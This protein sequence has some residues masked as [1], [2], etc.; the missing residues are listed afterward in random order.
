MKTNKSAKMI[1]ASLIGCGLCC[2]ALFLPLAAGF[3]GASVFGFSLG[4]ILCGG[5]F[6]ILAI[7][8]FGVYLS[9]RKRFCVTPIRE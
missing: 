4:S 3:M 6:F 7:V 8:L 2:L 9:K 5:F 1:V